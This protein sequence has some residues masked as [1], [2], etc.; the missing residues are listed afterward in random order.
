MFSALIETYE[1][2]K[3][4]SDA[5]TIM[6]AVGDRK[7]AWAWEADAFARACLFLEERLVDL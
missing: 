3:I 1:L 4:R 2:R 5:I 7:A 6:E